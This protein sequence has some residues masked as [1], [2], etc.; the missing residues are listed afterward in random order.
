MRKFWSPSLRW[1][2]NKKAY[3]FI[4]LQRQLNL[5]MM[6]HSNDYA[7]RLPAIR[8]KSICTFWL[9]L[10][11]TASL[12]CAQAPGNTSDIDWLIDVLEL[13]EGSVVADIGAGDGD[14]TIEIARYVGPE[15]RVYSSELGS[16]SVRKLREAVKNAGVSNVIVVEGH[17]DRTKLTEQCCDAIFLRRVYHHIK[18]PKNF[19][20]SLRQSLKKGGRL[21]IIDFEPRSSEADPGDRSSGGQHGVTAETVIEELEEAGFRLVSSDNPSGR[22]IYVVMEKPADSAE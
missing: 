10:L 15:G 17:P 22:N 9:I 12:S 13:K 19:N 7:N 18:K 5:D 14:Q 4:S 3:R 11:T 8:L 21:A 2:P 6:I 16:E 1:T 20:V